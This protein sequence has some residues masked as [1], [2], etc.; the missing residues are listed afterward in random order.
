MQ[1]M[2]IAQTN[3]VKGRWQKKLEPY[4]DRPAFLVLLA[5]VSAVNLFVALIPVELFISLRVF[6]LPRDWWKTALL[7]VIASL[8]G[9]YALVFLTQSQTQWD[10]AG[11][12]ARRIGQTRW[13]QVADF[14]NKRGAFGL[15]LAAVTIL[16]L[17]PAIIVCVLSKVPAW[18]IGLAIGLGHCIK[19]G[20]IAWGA[21]F[22]PKWFN[23][24]K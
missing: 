20:V 13:D 19:Y 15:F 21:A 1:A 24:T 2:Q 23:R 8:F 11:F 18:A 5:G 10:V 17:P 12:L 7:A 14:V 9:V 4:V 3:G 16:P 6:A 22:S